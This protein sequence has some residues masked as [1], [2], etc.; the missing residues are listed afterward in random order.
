[1]KDNRFAIYRGRTKLLL[2]FF[3]IILAISTGRFFYLQIIKG[4]ELRDLR[5]QNINDFEYI[6]P[7]RGRILSKDGIVLAEDRKIYSIAIDLEQKPS[8]E[9]I[10]AF[11]NIF[12]DR[13]TFE[14]I[15]SKVEQS[16]KLRRS[17]IVLSTIGQEELA[18]FL[19]RGDSLT[20]FS[21]IEDY[22]RQYDPHPS[23]FHVLG[24]MGYLTES[25][26]DHFSTRINDYDPKLWR[27]VGKSGIERVYEHELQGKHGKKFFQRNARG[28]RRVITNEEPFSEGDEITISIDYEAQKLA[29]ELMQG[30]KGSVVV[31]DLKD[32]SIPVAVSTPSISAND[33]KDISSSQY[34][35]LLNDSSRPL[36]NRAFM[37][38]Y[39]PGSSI[40]PLFAT[41]A[42]SNSYTNWDETIFDDGF[43][44]FEEEQRVF[45][46]WKEGGHGYTD[47]NKAL[48]ESSN[49]FFMNLSVKYEKSKFVE[50]LKSSSFGSKLC[51]DCYPH[52]YSPLID[53][54]WK[55]KN[56][57][58]DLFKG[59]FINLG[60][61]QGYM[62]TTPLHLSL[63]AGMLA[64]KGQYKLPHLVNKNDLDFSIDVEIE[65]ADWVKL[66]QA[67]IDVVY[68]SNGTG[69]RIKAGNLNLAGK[70][71][72]AQVVD[73]DSREEYDQ[74]RENINLRDHA[75]FIGY[76]PFD[77]PRYS[78]AVIVENGESGGRVAGPI[79]RDVLKEL[80]NDT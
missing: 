56:F 46:A 24:H 34:Q 58:K 47:L 27:K 26:T 7:K 78:I 77:D 3:I 33:L 60:I 5:E 73:I 67:L 23:F 1:L 54:A 68:S 28:D 16:L 25:D 19:V 6:Y 59:D 71:G 13:A 38:L 63:I 36:F 51:E 42:I 65:E 61:G 21:I 70:S 49:P 11:A 39:P 80:L 10:Q 44:R 20:G 76:A 37:G 22:E 4:G 14:E 31:I 15:E 8:K 55:R 2:S 9:S 75:I 41:F 79:A 43:F 52:Q 18:K 30:N 69:Y 29:Y 35:E 64:S 48:I 50:L 66:N 53:D 62:L 32:F 57:G 17:E 74:V 45:N 72:T 12:A 40:K